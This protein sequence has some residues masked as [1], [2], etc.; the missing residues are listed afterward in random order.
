M[1]CSYKMVR[2]RRIKIS[3]SGPAVVAGG[4]QIFSVAD[5]LNILNL[6]SV[7]GSATFTRGDLK[8]ATFQLWLDPEKGYIVES[9]IRPGSPPQYH[10]VGQAEAT[11]LEALVPDPSFIARMFHIA[12]PVSN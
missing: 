4:V 9:R 3:A 1:G 6:P 7:S 10:F 11:R 5:L 8:D 2:G 12:E